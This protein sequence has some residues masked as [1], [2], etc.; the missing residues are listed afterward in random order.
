MDARDEFTHT[1]TIRAHIRWSELRKMLREAVLQKMATELRTTDEV[2][3]D[4]K[5]L[6]EGSPAYDVQ[7][8]DAHIT[9]VQNFL[10]EPRNDG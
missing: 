7:Q 2:K 1:R 6:T 4:I 9:I 5:Q 8:W 3:V 10:K